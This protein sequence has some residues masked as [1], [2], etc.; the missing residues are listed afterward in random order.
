MI[1][2]AMKRN[3]DLLYSLTDFDLSSNPQLSLDPQG[4][5]VFIQE[6]HTIA[7]LNLSKC[8]LNFDVVSRSSMRGVV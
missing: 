5:L 8:G 7:S 6:P 3:T 1:G 2:Q 4:T